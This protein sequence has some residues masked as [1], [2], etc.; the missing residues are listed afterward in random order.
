MLK[1]YTLSTSSPQAKALSGRPKATN[2]N[3]EFVILQDYLLGVKD[4][5]SIFVDCYLNEGQIAQVKSIAQNHPSPIH[6]R[7]TSYSFWDPSSSRGVSPSK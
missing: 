2:H 4:S 7:F 6:N 5:V 3:R 1:N